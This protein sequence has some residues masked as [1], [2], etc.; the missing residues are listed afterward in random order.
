MRIQLMY[1]YIYIQVI[2]S[3]HPSDM[4]IGYKK[5]NKHSVPTENPHFRC[6]INQENNYF[7]LCELLQISICL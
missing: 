2:V 7:L 4:Y 5:Q 1:T 3:D 6:Q